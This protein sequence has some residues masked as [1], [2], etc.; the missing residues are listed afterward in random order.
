M[1]KAGLIELLPEYQFNHQ[2]S[3]KCKKLRLSLLELVLS[4]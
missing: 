1:E 3:K 4:H 2:K